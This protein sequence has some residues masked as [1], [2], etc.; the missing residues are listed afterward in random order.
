MNCYTDI[1]VSNN[2]SIRTTMIKIDSGAVRFAVAVDGRK[3][4]GT[5][6]DGDIRR[7]LINGKELNDSI[8]DVINPEPYYVHENYDKEKTIAELK[9]RSLLA[10]PVVNSNNE[11]VNILTLSDLESKEKYSNPVFIMAG[12]FGTRLKPLTDNCPKPMLKVGDKPILETLILQFKKYGFY[13]FYFSTHYL[14]NVIMDYFGNG[15]KWEVEI[16]YVHESTPLGTGG[17][18]GLLPKD[19][20]N[21]SIIMIN[22]DVLTKLD[23]DSLLK[24]HLKSDSIATMCVREFDYQVPYGVIEADDGKIIS[25]KEKPTYRFHV[26]AGIYVVHPKLIKK[27]DMEKVDMPTLLE[28]NFDRKVSIFPFHEYWLDIGKKDDFQRAQVDITQLGL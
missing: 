18:L 2:D 28:R 25:M 11:V 17:A 4:I 14:P 24:F 27:M 9:T 20:I 21:E 12:G 22:G 26:N 5:I 3:I 16:N 15:S 19:E 1:L 10:V 13:K 8:E 7:S 23:F 6:T